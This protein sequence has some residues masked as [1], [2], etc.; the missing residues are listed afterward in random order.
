MVAKSPVADT[1]QSAFGF[2][3]AGRK[4]RFNAKLR[5]T[6]D[7]FGIGGGD[8]SV[9]PNI[10][11]DSGRFFIRLFGLLSVIRLYLL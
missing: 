2:R 10:P 1:A 11:G 3:S 8:E 5:I 9:K 6:P 4:T 7:R